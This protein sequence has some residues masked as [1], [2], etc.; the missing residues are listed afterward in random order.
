MKI[1][2]LIVLS[3]CFCNLSFSQKS[4][5][6]SWLMYFG[7]QKMN[8]KWNWHNEVQVRNYNFIGDT[9]QLLL[10]TGIG[11]NLSEDNNNLLLGYGFINTQ[12][13]VPNSDQKTDSNEHRIYQQ[14]IT[15]QSFGR[16]FL[17]HR[18]RI[19]ERF[20]PND[21][22]IRFRYFLGINIPFNKKKVETNALYLSAYNEIFIN[23]ESPLFD[24]NRLYEAL[25]YVIHK[26]IKIEA[27]FMAQT[28]EN[29][30][31]NQFQI[32]IFNNLPF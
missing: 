15:R 10:R 2:N 29:S 26:N 30:N 28:L 4:E 27:G 16:I 17:Q 32:A 20:I 19:E 24:R 22:Q 3:I 1:I 23:A 31:R 14:F 25:G 12:K 13:Y 21:F 5:T 6:G 7:N 11:Y 9:N 18:Y 8:P